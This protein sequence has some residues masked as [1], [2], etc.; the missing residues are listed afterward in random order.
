[1][2]KIVYLTSAAVDR[3]MVLTMVSNSVDAAMLVHNKTSDMWCVAGID[4]TSRIAVPMH[5]DD[6]YTE[7]SPLGL[8]ICLNSTLSIELSMYICAYKYSFYRTQ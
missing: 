7:H 4:D 8:A 3:D 1:M 5:A 2:Y 6:G